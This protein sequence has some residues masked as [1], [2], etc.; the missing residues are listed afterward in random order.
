MS[1]IFYSFASIAGNIPNLSEERTISFQRLQ[2]KLF[3]VRQ[4]HPAISF[5][6]ETFELLTFAAIHHTI[7]TACRDRGDVVIARDT[8]FLSN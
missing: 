6:E 2:P 5:S 3:Y 1:I 7:K 4:Q 8:C